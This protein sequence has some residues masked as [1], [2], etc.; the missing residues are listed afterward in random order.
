M[1]VRAGNMLVQRNPIAWLLRNFLCLVF[2]YLSAAVIA[3]EPRDHGLLWEISRPGA[4]SSYLFGTIHSE[5]PGVLALSASVR[6]SFSGARR[7]VLE[8]MMDMDSMAYASTAMLMMDGRKLSELLGSMLFRRTAALMEA[9]G[10]SEVV[11]EHMKPWAVAINLAMPAPETG[12]VL[13]YSL[14]Q[15]A[16]ADGKPV[17][18]LETIQEQLG[19]FDG[20][21]IED[22]VA[23]LKDTVENHDQ[24]AVMHRTLLDAWKRQDLREMMAINEASLQT[25]DPQLSHMFQQE[26]LID[27]NLRMLER[28]QEHL[29]AGR[30]F[31][32]VGALHLPGE[33]GLLSL[34]G[35]RGYSLK[36]VY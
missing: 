6:Q 4:E 22:Q 12:V 32:A 33:Q 36:R 35:Q 30:A 34:L 25:G 17:Y 9:H 16:M 2:L 20:M 19:I 27:R 29:E 5:D 18:G 13:D 10:V 24:I 28:M 11:L 26:L 1:N 31:V 7:V 14:Y 8:V 15:Q 21:K 23:L 3:E